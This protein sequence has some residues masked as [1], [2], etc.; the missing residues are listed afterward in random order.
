MSKLILT[1]VVRHPDTDAPVALI[2]GTELPEWAEGLVH[3]DNLVEVPVEPER[4][5]PDF[6]RVASCDAIFCTRSS[7]TCGGKFSPDVTR[8]KK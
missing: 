3:P 1:I 6:S 7:T 8:T 5:S 2:E 4:T